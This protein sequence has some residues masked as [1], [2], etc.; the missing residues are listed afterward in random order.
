MRELISTLLFYARS[1]YL[2]NL[3]GETNNENILP[4]EPDF[5]CVGLTDAQNYIHRT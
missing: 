1:V 2:L 3:R 5:I 4:P